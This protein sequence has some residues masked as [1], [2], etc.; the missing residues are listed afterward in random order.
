MRRM[1]PPGSTA[2]PRPLH[3]QYGPRTQQN[4]LSYPQEGWRGTCQQ[5]SGQSLVEEQV[6]FSSEDFLHLHAAHRD[7]AAME[8]LG[9]CVGVGGSARCAPD[10]ARVVAAAHRLAVVRDDCSGG[11]GGLV[12]G[13]GGGGGEKKEESICVW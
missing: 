6:G 8:P 9:R 3:S 12:G 11:G 5:T 10:I 7:V 1:S 13:W 2:K 4:I